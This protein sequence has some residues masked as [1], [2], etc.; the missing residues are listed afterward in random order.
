MTGFRIF[1]ALVFVAIAAYTAVTVA[2]HGLGL[3]SVF[4]NDMLAMA[5]P[6][7]FNFDFMCFLALSAFWVSWRHGFSPAGLALGVVA[8]FGGAFFLSAYLLWA[9]FNVD[10]DVAALL[11]GPERAAAR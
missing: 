8:F 2:N 6:G 10:G 11:M 5:W 3:F 7:Q 4:I 9:S 1:Q